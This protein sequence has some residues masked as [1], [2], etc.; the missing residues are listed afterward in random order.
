MRKECPENL[1]LHP[2]V[3]FVWCFSKAMLEL[4]PFVPHVLLKQSQ[5]MSWNVKILHFL[6]GKEPGQPWARSAFCLSLGGFLYI[7]IYCC[8]KP[9]E[10]LLGLHHL[11]YF[12][13]WHI[14]FSGTPLL[15]RWQKRSICYMKYLHPLLFF[16]L[17]LCSSNVMI[18]ISA[19]TVFRKLRSKGMFHFSKWNTSTF[20]RHTEKSSANTPDSSWTARIR[21][22]QQ[23]LHYLQFIH[24]WK[25]I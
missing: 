19:S 10:N 20:C 18:T 23:M 16:F 12:N 25:L 5:Q 22:C 14:Y 8:K 6:A 1:I 2:V 11:I 3:F 7:C 13:M 9:Q 21:H 17:S 24:T 4:A 15:Q